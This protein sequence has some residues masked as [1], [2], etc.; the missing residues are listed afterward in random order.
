VKPR[1][2]ADRLDALTQ[3]AGSDGQFDVLVVGGGITGAGVFSLAARRGYRVALIEQR[4]FAWGTSSRSGK[5]VHGGLRYMAQGQF[6]TSYHSVR[7]REVMLKSYAG[8]VHPLSFAIPVGNGGVFMR[9]AL[10][11]VL[12]LYDGMAGRPSREFHPGTSLTAKLPGLTGLKSGAWTFTDGTTDDARLVLRV[13]AEG[14]ALGHTAVNYVE[15][16][17]PRL[18]GQGRVTGVSARDVL[19]G[20]E[21]A[22]SARAVVSATGAWADTLR[23]AVGEKPRMRPLRG[24][25]ILIPKERLPVELAI[26][27]KSPKDRRNMYLLPWE[28]R[29]LIGTTDLDHTAP[30]NTEPAITAAEGA[31]LLEALHASF[32][33]AG[34]TKSD[35]ISTYAGVRPVVSSGQK[36][37]SKESRDEAVWS[38]RGLVTITGGKLTTFRRMAERAL[39]AAA[40]FAGPARA[41]TPVAGGASN[42]GDLPTR[43]LGRFGMLADAVA[44]GDADPSPDALS[45]VPGTNTLWAELDWAASHEQV[46][47][48]DDLLLR[49]TRI[50]NLLPN[51]GAD[52]L[53]TI[54][55]RVAPRLGWDTARW[56]AERARYEALWA[57][58]YSPDLVRA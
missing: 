32:P 51:G 18:D 54:S 45:T 16:V 57:Q 17:G 15:A 19:T 3:P 22:I 58:A 1:T 9:Y 47:H 4:D 11:L 6:R 46:Q 55:A 41:A 39:E 13:L 33:D 42:V 25:H 23:G 8:L 10:G 14:E 44:R 2:R 31:Y 35:I 20:R 52:L 56:Q 29:V 50:G 40:P 43:L 24:S 7:D 21:F 53:E 27:L 34:I 36:D 49:R 28:G 26:A 30:L 12:A 5:L 48:L 38:D 37:P